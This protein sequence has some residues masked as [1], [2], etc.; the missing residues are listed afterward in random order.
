[1]NC[2]FRVHIYPHCCTL[3]LCPASFIKSPAVCRALETPSPLY[4]FRRHPCLSRTMWVAQGG[5]QPRG[6]CRTG[7]SPSCTCCTPIRARYADFYR[8]LLM[9]SDC[10]KNSYINP[11]SRAD[12]I[13]AFLSCS[14]LNYWN[15]NKVVPTSGVSAVGVYI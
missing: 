10:S 3:P 5:C 13:A 9:R 8:N 12:L 2:S 11:N 6:A 7:C 15:L 1:M 14:Y 4:F